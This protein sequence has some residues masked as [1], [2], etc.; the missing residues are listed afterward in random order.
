MESTKMAQVIASNLDLP[1]RTKL[2]T[3]KKICY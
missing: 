3:P 1:E 2:S